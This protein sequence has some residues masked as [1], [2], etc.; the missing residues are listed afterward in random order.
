MNFKHINLGEVMHTNKWKYSSIREYGDKYKLAMSTDYAVD[1][2]F[3]CRKICKD[4]GIKVKKTNLK[5]LGGICNY[6][7]WVIKMAI[8]KSNMTDE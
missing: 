3:I 4:D 8:I 2:H 1:I 5:F 7:Q 6:P